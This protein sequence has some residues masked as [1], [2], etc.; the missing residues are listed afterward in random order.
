MAHKVNDY[1]AKN[2]KAARATER[3]AAA[4]AIEEFYSADDA[5]TSYE[6]EREAI[7]ADWDESLEAE[8]AEADYFET[9]RDEAEA[10]IYASVEDF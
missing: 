8:E 1:S 6:D 9:W 7:E 3:Q 10:D 5:D 2:R 4:A